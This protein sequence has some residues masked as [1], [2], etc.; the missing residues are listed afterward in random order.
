M[1]VVS[2]SGACSEDDDLISEELG[3]VT[4]H[5]RR[6]MPLRHGAENIPDRDTG[7]W[8]R[9]RFAILIARRVLMPDQQKI[10]GTIGG[11]LHTR[12]ERKLATLQTPIRISIPG[13]KVC[14][15]ECKSPIG[16]IPGNREERYSPNSAVEI[17]FAGDAAESGGRIG[18]LL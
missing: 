4:L 12:L 13:G 1:G 7:I 16:A 8:E 2:S 6:A 5:L 14:G 10:P 15:A 9:T 3:W 18:E 17:E 11:K